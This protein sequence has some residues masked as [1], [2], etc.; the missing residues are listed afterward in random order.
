[1]KN[2]LFNQHF[3]VNQKMNQFVIFQES[4]QNLPVWRLKACVFLAGNVSF[5]CSVPL[6]PP[7]QYLCMDIVLKIYI[8]TVVIYV[9]SH[10]SQ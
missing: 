5:F 1:M 6:C 4:K 10:N 7:W 9:D 2:T 8:Q 3:S